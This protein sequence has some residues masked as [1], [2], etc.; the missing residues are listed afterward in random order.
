MS[1]FKKFF[2]LLAD[3]VYPNIA[4]RTKSSSEYK[5]DMPEMIPTIFAIA[6]FFS[7]R[8]AIAWR[9]GQ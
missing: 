7:A 6:L 4:R 8:L 2:F 9:A 1:N 5:D 3:T